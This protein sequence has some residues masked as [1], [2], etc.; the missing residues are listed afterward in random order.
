MAIK[1]SDVERPGE[2]RR[3]TRLNRRRFGLE[4]DAHKLTNPHIRDVSVKLAPA[5]W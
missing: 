5:L 1:K 3:K 4:L 2:L